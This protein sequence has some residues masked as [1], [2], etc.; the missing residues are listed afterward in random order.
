MES[1]QNT[2]D[3]HS[4]SVNAVLYEISPYIWPRYNGTRLYLFPLQN[5]YIYMLKWDIWYM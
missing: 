5:H 3:L 4:T 1:T 2:L